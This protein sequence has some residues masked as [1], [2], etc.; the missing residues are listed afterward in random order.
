MTTARVQYVNAPDGVAHTADTVAR[1]ATLAREGSHTY[2]IRSLA[3]RITHHVPGKDTRGEL[4]AIYQWVR[5]TIRY[6]Y[7]P[8]GLEWIQAPD[9]TVQEKA[10]D[11]DDMA[12]LIAALAQSIGHRTRFRTVGKTDKRQSH[13]HAQAFDGQQWIALDPVLEPR[14]SST[15]PRPELGA[16]GFQAPGAERLYNERG[17]PMHGIPS[18]RAIQLWQPTNFEVSPQGRPVIAT[19]YRSRG[20]AGRPTPI[21][22][23]L[24]QNAYDPHDLSGQLNGLGFNFLK[25]IGSVAKVAGAVGVPGASA[26]SMG[27]DV[28]GSLLAKKKAAAQTVPRVAVVPPGAV[29]VAGP[30]A[31]APAGY[32]PQGSTQA[33]IN[34]APIVAAGLQ[35]S[36][37]AQQLLASQSRYAI[38]AIAHGQQTA[39]PAPRRRQKWDPVTRRWTVYQESGLGAFKP[40]I[41]F[42]MGAGAA[43]ESSPASDLAARLVRSI[44]SK[45][46]AYDRQLA[47]DFQ[48]AAGIGVDGKYGGGTAGAVRYF[49]GK[50]P[51]P[52]IF[53]PTKEIRYTPPIGGDANARSPFPIDPRVL[54]YDPRPRLTGGSGLTAATWREAP[55]TAT[56]ARLL[57]EWEARQARRAATPAPVAVPVSSPINY[58]PASL[59]RRQMAAALVNTITQI[60]RQTGAPPAG[61]VPGAIGYQTAAGIST[62]GKYGPQ[63]RAAL[64]A[65]LGVAASTLPATAYDRTRAPRARRP[66][67]AVAPAVFEPTH[68]T[69]TDPGL[70]TF[71]GGGRP[72]EAPAVASSDDNTKWWILA[73]AYYLSKKQRQT[74][75]RRRAR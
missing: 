1:M 53:R 4:A 37:E 27:I 25:A 38:E 14:Q 17:Q 44:R 67:R 8:R 33:P 13:V 31:Q 6:R 45:G 3:T 60:T 42:A 36:R 20:S 73:G 57:R 15:A 63:T 65:D 26:L 61:V 50:A 69:P 64:A 16:F 66:R 10:G 19:Q 47:S 55:A 48:R 23:A 11:C 56:E 9:R 2:A 49:T 58:S 59:T 12:I 28:G 30:G 46:R 71:P 41:T 62:D 18:K 29:A 35:A 40:S 74:N 54:P 43:M 34:V 5:D 68:T 32:A 7:D 39:A 70:P 22:L 51:P 75:G 52:A 24:W 72:A 21:R